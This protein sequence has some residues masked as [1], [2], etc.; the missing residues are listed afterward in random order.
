MRAKY[1]GAALHLRFEEGFAGLV[2][3]TRDRRHTWPLHQPLHVNGANPACGKA[4]VA[5]FGK[6]PSKQRQTLN[7]DELLEEWAQAGSPAPHFP[8]QREIVTL[9]R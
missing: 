1:F 4:A 6:M 8:Y 2:D 5:R 3:E 7:N 9:S